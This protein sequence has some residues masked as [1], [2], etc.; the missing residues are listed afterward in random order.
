MRSTEYAQWANMHA[1]MEI[2]S[3]L[4]SFTVIWPSLSWKYQQ[5]LDVIEKAN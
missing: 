3:R 4:V 5:K 1:H 2:V